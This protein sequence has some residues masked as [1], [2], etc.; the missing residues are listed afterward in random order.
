MTHGPRKCI[1]SALFMPDLLS[2]NLGSFGA[3]CKLSA[4]S[5]GCCS[6]RFHLILTKLAGEYGNHGG[7]QAITYFGDLPKFKYSQHF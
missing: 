2:L 4:V 6:S 3:L 7:N 5:K 1:C